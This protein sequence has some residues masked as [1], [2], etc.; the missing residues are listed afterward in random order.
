M[1]LNLE[2]LIEEMT[3]TIKAGGDISA[4]KK[5]RKLASF[6]TLLTRLNEIPH[7]SVPQAD[8][9]RVKNQ[10]LDRIT[11]PQ[12]E[13]KQKW[14]SFAGPLPHTLRLATSIVGGLLIVI[15]LTLGTAVAALNSVPGQAIYPLKKIVENIQMKLTPDSEKTNLQIKFANNR[16]DELQQV[17]QQQQEGKLS[18]SETQKIVAATVNDLQTT[19]S[20][21]AKSSAQQPATIVTNLADLS[22][23][24]K[25]AS[26]RSEGEIKIE[27]EKAV[28]NTRISQE[29]AIKNI[30]QA[31]IKIEGQPVEI[32]NLVSASGKLTA[33]SETSVSIGTA[34]FLL[35]KD[36]KYVNTAKKDLAIGQLVDISGEIKDNKSYAYQITLVIDPKVKGA[37][38]TQTDLPETTT[39][40][41][42]SAP[43][44]R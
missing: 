15:S 2:K 12:A 34:K 3:N 32:D 27:L 42:P 14:F 38:T 35:T 23:K 10:I 11:L 1:E 33:V 4:Y 37:E 8:L 19:T 29:E 40:E 44:S 7:A 43:A 24:L 9:M 6:V 25:V 28:Q 30:Q 21:A 18:A 41:T 20:A 17:L 13:T 26:T 39:E 22:S 36:T 16:V 5:N 31:G